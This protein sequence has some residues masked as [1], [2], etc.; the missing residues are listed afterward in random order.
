MKKI[1]LSLAAFTSIISMSCDLNADNQA[2]K[3]KAALETQKGKHSYAIGNDVGKSVKRQM[4]AMEADLDYAL[5][6]QGIKD[7]LDTTKPALM[8][9]SE[10]TVA[11]N[12]FIMEMQR[13]YITKDSIA[14]AKV[15]AENLVKQTEFL[16]KNKAEAGVITTESGLQY[17]T[18]TEGKGQTAKDGDTVVVHYAGAFL[19]GSEF[20]SSFKRNQPLSEVLAEGKFIK[21]W[22][23]MLSL[24]NKGQKVKVWIPSSL[25]Y[26]EN[27]GPVIPGNTLLVFDMELLD[28]KPAK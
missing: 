8:S 19:D 2:V 13:A 3:N 24:M 22:I 25:A 6:L 18:V 15:A 16:E 26:G 10:A 21:G 9:D 4:D 17:T 7:K 12:E 23:E 28:I 27:G 1:L 14:R 11:L 20:D 5:I